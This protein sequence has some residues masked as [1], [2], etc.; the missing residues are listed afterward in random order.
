MAEADPSFADSVFSARGPFAAIA[1]AD[2]AALFAP[3]LAARGLVLAVSGGPDSLALLLLAARWRE[4]AGRASFP[5]M[6]VATVDHALRASAAD[7][8]HMV[9]HLAC[10]MG[11]PARVL[12]WRGEKPA[13]GIQEAARAARY[14]LLAQ[15]AREAGAS[16]IVTAHH[17]DDQAET[18]LMRLAAGSGIGGLAAMRPCRALDEATVGEGE[19]LVLVRPLLGLTRARLDAIV[20]EA[21]IQA[22]DDPANRDPRFTRARL[23]ALAPEREALG[24]TTA[25]LG[26][27]AARCARADAALAAVAVQRY[28][29]LARHEGDRLTIG[30]DLWREPDEIV[31]RCVALGVEAVAGGGTN[32]PLRLERLE[33]LVE[34]L[35][36]AAKEGNMLRRTLHHAVVRI[37]RSGELDI[38]REPERRRGVE[39][40]SRKA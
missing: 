10:A 13:R 32:A 31:L 34:A 29:A 4:V 30:A 2:V 37:A 21:G 39:T 28:A 24:L 26:L 8:A 20:R 1:D 19:P 16:H 25:R 27:L 38:R 11:L 17:A 7:E 33:R 5:A 14:G 18:V 15:A 23:R 9:A 6:T 35:R 12:V 40:G 22:V 36:D 3:L